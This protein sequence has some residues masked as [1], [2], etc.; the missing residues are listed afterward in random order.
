MTR[1]GPLALILAG[2]LGLTLFVFA[3]SYEGRANVINAQRAGYLRGIQDRETLINLA[4]AVG[5][6]PATDGNRLLELALAVADAKLVQP[7]QAASLPMPLR[8]YAH[9]S[10]VTAY[11][12]ASVWP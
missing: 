2:L 12:A 4:W 5:H 11:P 6:D 7:A 8:R 3:Q 9:F 10:C 1:H